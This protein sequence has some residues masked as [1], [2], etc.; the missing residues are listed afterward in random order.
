MAIYKSG[1]DA[2]DFSRVYEELREANEGL[3]LC[4]ELHLLYLVASTADGGIF[5]PDWQR[6]F[7]IV[8][9]LKVEDLRVIERQRITMRR[10]QVRVE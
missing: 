8:E 9:G 2:E 7:H 3:V 10:L 4:S 1:L 6:L 5:I